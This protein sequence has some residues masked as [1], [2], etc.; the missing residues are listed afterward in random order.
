MR[1]RCS[2][3]VVGPSVLAGVVLGSV[4]AGNR[5]PAQAPLP[6]AVPA[7]ALPGRFWIVPGGESSVVV[8]DTAT[9]RS[10][11]HLASGAGEWADF[12]TP[13]ARN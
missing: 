5:S 7:A 4:L 11:S 2:L 1:R 13:M 10:W 6:G 3:F 9:G 8:L 12:G